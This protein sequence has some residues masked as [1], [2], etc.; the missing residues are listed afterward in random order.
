[1]SAA[2]ALKLYNFSGTVDAIIDVVAYL[3]PHDHEDQYFRQRSLVEFNNEAIRTFDLNNSG[4]FVKVA[5]LG[6]FTK[7]RA[8]TDVFIEA[9][10][11]A[12]ADGRECTFQ[13]RVDGVKARATTFDA[14]FDGSE[15]TIGGGDVAAFDYQQVSIRTLFNGL[16]AGTHTVSLW[17]YSFLNTT[18]HHNP[19]A[20]AHVLTVEETA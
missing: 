19:G 11:H 18:C 15:A 16:G 7:A 6:S 9:P 12:V 4:T 8:D 20:Y 3:V 10:S 14:K 2:G 13:L 5:D 1:M 17:V